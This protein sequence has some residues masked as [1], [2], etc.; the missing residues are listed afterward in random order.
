MEEGEARNG[1]SGMG[2]TTF[3]IQKRS[4]KSRKNSRRSTLQLS[5]LSSYR[6]R[7][8]DMDTANDVSQEAEA[9]PSTVT[10]PPPAPLAAPPAPSLDGLPTFASI[11][12]LLSPPLLLALSVLRFSHP[13]PVQSQ[14]LPLALSGHDIV[15]RARTGSGKTLAYGLPV[16]QKIYKTKEAVGRTSA[17]FQRIRGLILVPTRELAEQVTAHIAKICLGS[18]EDIRVVNVAQEASSSVIKLSLADRPDIVVATPSRALSYIESKA[19]TLTHLDA[20]VLDEADL[21]LSYGHDVAMRT[22]FDGNHLPKNYQSYLMSATMSQD[23]EQVRH[24]LSSSSNR[25]PAKVLNVQ[26]PTH[27]ANLTQYF[28]H[29]TEDLKF[30]LLYVSLKLRVIRGKSLIFVNDTDR[31][32][33]LRLYLETF[34]IRSCVLNA[35]MPGNSRLKVVEEFNKGVYEVIIATDESGEGLGRGEDAT[36]AVKESEEDEEEGEEEDLPEELA[37]E[38][39]ADDATKKRKRTKEGDS[40]KTSKR[41]SSKKDAISAASRLEYGVSRG[42][43]FLNVSCVVNFD[44]PTSLAAYIHRIGR[45][46][47]AH[48]SGIALSFIVPSS[49]ALAANPSN[50]PYISTKGGQAPAVKGLASPTSQL[51]PSTWRKITAHFS[52]LSPPVALIPFTSLA[53]S[54]LSSFTY[55]S[56]STLRSITRA[57]VREARISE[58]K[59]EILR[60]DRLKEGGWWEERPRDWEYLRHDRSLGEK[61]GAGGE[62]RTGTS[63][64]KHVPSYLIP[65]GK[66]VEKSLR[67]EDR[68]SKVSYDEETG[69]NLGYVGLRKQAGRGGSSSRGGRGGSRGG[70]RGASRGGRG[71][72]KKKDPLRTG[73]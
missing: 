58:L 66:R 51:D 1:Q 46:A 24:L 9:G 16:V 63:Y 17:D 33:K 48:Q 42:I 49:K 37:E 69:R 34:G 15:A 65:G 53:P 6:P 43:D 67:S 55:R 45:T 25:K 29:L 20:V 36:P 28:V 10:A 23:V 31:G 71:G 22:L 12:H 26:D 7:H 38:T 73:K 52:S 18:K 56:E 44:L 35:E 2:D 62:K 72:T 54:V 19:L 70:G 40:T 11:A 60:S 32:Y 13:T 21:L 50:F 64:L 30:L 5:I 3:D 4:R 57:R 41:S 39:A 68:N 14:V 59:R 8:I 61:G 47:R 27:H